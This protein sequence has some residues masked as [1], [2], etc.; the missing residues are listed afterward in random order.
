MRQS[1]KYIKLP[2][3]FQ[4]NIMCQTSTRPHI[5]HE[6]IWDRGSRRRFCHS[7]H[8]R[9]AKSIRARNCWHKAQ[10]WLETGSKTKLWL[11]KVFC[12]II[13]LG[14]VTKVSEIIEKILHNN[15]LVFFLESFTVKIPAT[16]FSCLF[17]D[18]TR[19]CEN[20][21]VIFLSKF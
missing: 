13:E 11:S 4:N 14:I 3:K 16:L 10:A 1:R 5:K 19:N 18:K 6:R 7:K 8:E 17:Q 21:Y 12:L 20:S 2:P 15:S 9:Q